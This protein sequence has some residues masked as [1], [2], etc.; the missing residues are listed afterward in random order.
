MAKW[1]MQDTPAYKL[2][3]SIVKYKM[4]D[5]VEKPA[6]YNN[7]TI[8]CIDY[9]KDSMSLEEYRGYLRGNVIKYQHR[10]K[11]KGKELEDLQKAQW[12]LNKLIE[13]YKE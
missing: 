11:Y 10:H 5:V 2:H 8:E 6:H 4:A 9:I 13:T 3:E 1:N 12:Y 7:G